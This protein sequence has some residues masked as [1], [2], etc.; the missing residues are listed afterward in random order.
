MN[1]TDTLSK[2]VTL[3]PSS[4]VL[5]GHFQNEKTISP[6]FSVHKRNEEKDGPPTYTTGVDVFGRTRVFPFRLS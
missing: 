2:T 6:V 4:D 5:E 1:F 3:H